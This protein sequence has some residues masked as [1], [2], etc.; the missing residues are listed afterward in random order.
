MGATPPY[1]GNYYIVGPM[2]IFPP[3]L[4]ELNPDVITMILPALPIGSNLKRTGGRSSA[5][6]RASD[7]AATALQAGGS[8]ASVWKARGELASARQISSAAGKSKNLSF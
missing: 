2:S 6:P 4:M 7:L 3:N 1:H 5:I 8:R